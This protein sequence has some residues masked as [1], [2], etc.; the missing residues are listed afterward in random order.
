M[1]D[2]TQAEPVE[3]SASMV[4]PRR[5]QGR[6]HPVRAETPGVRFAP[7]R[8]KAHRPPGRLGGP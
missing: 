8:R 2:A 6:H 5:H 1:S 4:I 7:A 3:I